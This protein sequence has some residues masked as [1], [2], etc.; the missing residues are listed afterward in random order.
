M[1]QLPSS[2]S[3]SLKVSSL[4]PISPLFFFFVQDVCLHVSP[5]PSLISPLP[6][7]LIYFLP[8]LFPPLTS[9]SFSDPLTSSHFLSLLNRSPPSLHFSLFYSSFPLFHSLSPHLLSFYSPL[10][11]S[12]IPFTPSPSSSLFSSSSLL[13]LFLSSHHQCCSF[14]FSPFSSPF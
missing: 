3:S 9:L 6:P 11:S 1:T 12:F 10:F 2:A 8:Q 4:Y 7:S 14:L 13:H 5:P